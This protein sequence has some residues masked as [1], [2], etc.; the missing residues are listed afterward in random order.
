MA[1]NLFTAR[2]TDFEYDS[3]E[4]CRCIMLTFQTH[5]DTGI[6]SEHSITV[7]KLSANWQS[8]AGSSSYYITTIFPVLFLSS[9]LISPLHPCLDHSSNRTGVLE[10]WSKAAASADKLTGVTA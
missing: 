9:I 7:D 8:R 1:D 4:D 5:N 6:V 2:K 10:H 3:C